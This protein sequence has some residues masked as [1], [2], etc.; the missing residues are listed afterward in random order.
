[1]LPSG[2]YWGTEKYF[3]RDFGIKKFIG[4]GSI[5]SGKVGFMGAPDAKQNPTYKEVCQGDTKQVEVYDLEFEGD[6]T[7]FENL[8]KHFFMFHDPTTLH[9]Q[10]EDVGFQYSSVIYVYDEKQVWVLNIF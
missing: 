9:R 6:E 2:C 8:C 3:K 5:K 7:T 10:E 1:M 4:T